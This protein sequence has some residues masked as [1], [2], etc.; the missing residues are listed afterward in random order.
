MAVADGVKEGG[1][2]QMCILGKPFWLQ[3]GSRPDG[4]DVTAREPWVSVSSPPHTGG[5]LPLGNKKSV[6][7]SPDFLGGC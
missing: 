3:A 1:D 4:S 7:Q 5:K 6:G 2:T